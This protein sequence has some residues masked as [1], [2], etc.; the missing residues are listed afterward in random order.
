MLPI[1]ILVS[2]WVICEQPQLFKRL[3]TIL[4]CLFGFMLRLLSN[5]HI[6]HRE[7]SLMYLVILIFVCSTDY[8]FYS[9]DQKFTFLLGVA[10]LVFNMLSIF[11]YA[12]TYYNRPS[13]IP[14]NMGFD[15]GIL[16]LMSLK[17]HKI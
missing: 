1:H 5:V 13:L 4:L 8:Y 14:P 2:L 3:N 16:I 9:L 15:G 6:F 11:L 17:W 10:V 12:S 7:F